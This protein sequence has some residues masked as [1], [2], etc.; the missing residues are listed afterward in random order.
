M[1]TSLVKATQKADKAAAAAN[2]E[3]DRETDEYVKEFLKAR[4][5]WGRTLTAAEAELE[6][7]ALELHALQHYVRTLPTARKKRR[8]DQDDVVSEVHLNATLKE[9]PDDVA[10]LPDLDATGIEVDDP[11]PS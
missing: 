10:P 4:Y 6:G 2:T 1:A 3:V 11:L 5:K 8:L 9:D 7:Q